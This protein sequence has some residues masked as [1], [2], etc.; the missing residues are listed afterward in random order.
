MN[1]T[2]KVIKR[3]AGFKLQQLKFFEVS[4]HD[5]DGKIK[6]KGKQ[7]YQATQSAGYEQYFET[8]GEKKIQAKQMYEWLWLKPVQ[9]F[10]AMTN[11]SKELRS[12]LNEDFS[13]PGLTIDA[14]QFSEDGNCKTR[15]KR[16]MVILVEGVLIPTASRFTACVSSQIGCSLSCKFCA[17][18][19]ME[20]KR[21]LDFDEIYDEVAM[22]NQQCEKNT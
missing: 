12:K 2:K 17:T 18:G 6:T 1:A 7:E 22:I 19:Y 9:S 3:I 15:S 21:N 16:M 20:R 4:L 13:L 11:L 14:T 5:G 8:L 10:D